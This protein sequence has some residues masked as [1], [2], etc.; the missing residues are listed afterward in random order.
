MKIDNWHNLELHP[1]CE[2]FPEATDDDYDRLVASMKE[3]GY[4]DAEPIT[5]ID[6]DPNGGEDWQVLDG[7]HR[8][9]AAQDAGVIPTFAEYE[10][11][12]PLGYVT[13]KDM[14]RRHL[15]TGQKAALAASIANLR[16][17]QNANSEEAV[18]Q[19]EAA[20]KLGV[21]EAT[22]RRYKKLEKEAPELAEEVK[23]GNMSL[24]EARRK[25]PAGSNE[26]ITKENPK[27]DKQMKV[28]NDRIAD[29]VTAAI[30]EH[31]LTETAIKQAAAQAYLYGRQSMKEELS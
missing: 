22:V 29:I 31:G 19:K 13:A 3:Y 6:K 23:K 1:L 15:S 12:D 9:L 28:D 7:R 5:V 14:A 27:R 21:G 30:G 18:T 2:L 20:E 10:G 4:F 16:M 17:G 26:P 25:I 11:D 24:E 8:F